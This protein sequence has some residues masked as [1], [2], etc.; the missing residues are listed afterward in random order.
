MTKKQGDETYSERKELP[1]FIKVHLGDKLSS[2]VT[3]GGLS[4]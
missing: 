2:L 4:M 3:A 1:V